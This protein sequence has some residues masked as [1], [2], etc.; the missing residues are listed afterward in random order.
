MQHPSPADSPAGMAARPPS[1]LQRLSLHPSS[2]KRSCTV[3]RLRVLVEGRPNGRRLGQGEDLP[4]RGKGWRGKCSLNMNRRPAMFVVDLVHCSERDDD[5]LCGGIAAAD[6]ILETMI[7]A[8]SAL[9]A[10]IVRLRNE[11]M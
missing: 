8:A 11:F 4:R 9:N 1:I 5:A 7:E 3:A 2:E 6:D 10:R